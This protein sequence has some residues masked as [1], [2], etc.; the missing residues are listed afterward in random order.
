MKKVFK[1]IEKIDYFVFRKLYEKSKIKSPSTKLII[2]L[3]RVGYQGKNIKIHKIRSMYKYS[4]FLHQ[5]ML[6][7]EG[8]SS[9]GKINRDPGLL[10]SVDLSENTG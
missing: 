4:E 7:K 8:L 2:S 6:E 10:L 3:D 9:I 1:K 5:G